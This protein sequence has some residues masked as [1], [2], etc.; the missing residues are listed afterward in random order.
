MSFRTSAVAFTAVLLFIS[1]RPRPAKAGVGEALD[2]ALDASDLNDQTESRCQGKLGAKLDTL[3][4]ALRAAKRN[5]TDR[6][7]AAAKRKVKPAA[8]LAEDRCPDRI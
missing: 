4:D 2:A 7:I 8:D 6:S 5:P 3:I 1:V